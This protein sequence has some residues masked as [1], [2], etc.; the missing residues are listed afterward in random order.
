MMV[1]APSDSALVHAQA[2]GSGAA[3]APS[4][5]AGVVSR[6]SVRSAA[7]ALRER[8]LAFARMLLVGLGSS[9]V[10]LVVLV[11]CIRC[12]SVDATISR[13]VALVVS[14]LFLFFGCRSFAFRAGAGCISRQAKG[15]VLTELCGFPL[16]LLAFHGMAGYLPFIAPEFVSQAA[17]FLVFVVFAYPVRRCLVFRGSANAASGVLRH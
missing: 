6:L 9:G 14:G 11:L 8:W 4:V 13:L 7:P 2:S 10:D 16:N 17:N 3:A 12:L 5:S 15:F 1:L